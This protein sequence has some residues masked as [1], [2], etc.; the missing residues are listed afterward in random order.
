MH[1]ALT[2]SV[3][4]N[5]ST[6]LNVRLRADEVASR[7]YHLTNHA[8]Y[9]LT[10]IVLNDP[11]LPGGQASCESGRSIPPGGSLDCTASFTVVGGAQAAQVT[12]T[13]E[14]P[15]QLPQ[16]H[17]DASAGYL[18]I[19]AGLS[20][21]RLG[22]PTGTGLARSLRS[23][24]EAVP[25]QA[26]GTRRAAPRALT[27]VGGTV[28]LRYLLEA[29]GDVPITDVSVVEGLPG[30]GAVSCAGPDG[31][32]TL[33]P[34]QGVECQAGGTAHP[35]HQTGTAHADGLADDAT[36]GPDGAL[37]G[38]RRVSADA[39]GSYDGLSPAPPATAPAGAPTAPG[40][41][42]VPGAGAGAGA[43]VG[44]GTGAGAGAGVGAGAG[45]GAAPGVVG[46]T[47]T[48][49]ATGAGAAGAGAVGAPGAAALGAGGAAAVAGAAAPA[50]LL[51]VPI[52]AGGAAAAAPGQPAAVAP[53]AQVLTPFLPGAAPALIPGGAA[54]ALPASPFAA[55]GTLGSSTGLSGNLVGVGQV[56]PGG[57]QPGGGAASGPIPGATSGRSEGTNTVASPGAGASAGG[58]SPGGQALANGDEDWA[59]QEGE[60]N[61]WDI[62]GVMVLLLVILLPVLCVLAA[63]FSVRGRWRR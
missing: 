20:L 1:D 47:G 44:A 40:G 52:P 32:H 38:P 26:A 37:Q 10:D 23:V 9:Q 11:Q 41:G 45:A 3:S 14:A 42:T 28:E 57:G 18:G 29:F 5:T 48:G 43:G 56:N 19:T 49:T 4:T 39:P 46:G 17:A 35:G 22:A 31:G 58:P 30:V 2:L 7:A 36:V 53:A 24:P 16:A 34:G 33:T 62:T 63:A 54:F 21:I 27:E 25:E 6:D 50:G 55:P 61:P 59:P 51:P 60:E 15:N 13:A 12:A 8:E